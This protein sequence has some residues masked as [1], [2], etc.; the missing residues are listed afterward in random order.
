MADDAND[1][2]EEFAPGRLRGPDEVKK[3]LL[4]PPVKPSYRLGGVF[5]RYK[6][7]SKTLVFSDLKITPPSVTELLNL[8]NYYHAAAID[9]A[10]L[11]EALA[12]SLN[13]NNAKQFVLC[14][15]VLAG[16]LC[17]VGGNALPM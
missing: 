5:A 14:A 6:N 16:Y 3:L 15:D 13:K 12:D 2:T 10:A 9:R 1:V 7:Y 4:I 17:L 11:T 8:Q